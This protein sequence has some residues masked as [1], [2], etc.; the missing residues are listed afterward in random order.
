MTASHNPA[1]YVGMKFWDRDLELMSTEVLRKLFE[2]EYTKDIRIP[3]L[4]FNVNDLPKLLD[5]KQSD[6]YN[7]LSKKR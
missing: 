1:E 2:K 7:F 4:S 5:Q 6:L 3:Q